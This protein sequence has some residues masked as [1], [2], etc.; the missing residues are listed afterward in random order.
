MYL[1]FDIGTSSV[2]TAL[3]SN[4]G[5]AVRKVAT[6]YTLSSPQAGWYEGEAET[7]WQAVLQGFRLIL[8]EDR[9]RSREIHAICGCSQGETFVL[10]DERNR[11]VRPAVVWLDR[12]A[13]DEVQAFCEL[14]EDEAA[15][16]EATGIPRIDPAT[17]SLKLLWLL[18]H[19][20]ESYRRARRFAL[21]EDF[22]IHR[23]TG[24]WGAA[25][26]L[27]ATTG[28]I[29]IRAGSYLRPVV[30]LLELDGRLPPLTSEAQIVGSVMGGPA[31]E[32]GL[33]PR[34]VVVRG[35][36]DQTAS[37][38]GAANLAPGVITENTGSAMTVGITL[39]SDE[40]GRAFPF[41]C[42]PHLIPD[43]YLAL[44]FI[45]SAG[46]AYRWFRDEFGGKEIEAAGDRE[47]AY[48][49]LDA[50]A[51]GVPAGA[52]GLLFLPFLSGDSFSTGRRG[53]TGVFYGVTLSHRRAHFARA[54]LES[55]CYSLRQLIAQVGSSGVGVTEIRSTGGGARSELL[56]QMKADVCGCPVAITADEETSLLGAAIIASVA[57][58]DYSS[59]EEAARSM[60]AVRKRFLPDASN[61]ARYEQGFAAFSGLNDAMG[62][63]FARHVT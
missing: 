31:S 8:A 33:D 18:R 39:R 38:V 5:K 61:R 24:C 63:L 23:L 22:V 57:C 17:P 15:Y 43:L 46:S 1:T 56:L 59:L 28:L 30:D 9:T 54:I 55:I 44:P 34:T 27:M 36:M 3:Y 10:L 6:S 12:R 32:T 14:F 21:L 29:D 45:Q 48:P 49:L 52:D 2:K 62:G 20:Q 4:G 16:F 13:N 41:P 47:K 42:Q 35:T 7:Y 50:L 60:V 37:A 53:A 19:E 51:A 25:P 58:G 26:S 11:P 40:R